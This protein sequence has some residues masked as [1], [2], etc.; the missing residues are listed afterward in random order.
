MTDNDKAQ[1]KRRVILEKMYVRVY[2]GIAN[3]IPPSVLIK[4]ID[5]IKSLEE[6]NP[7]GVIV[8]KAIYE[9]KIDLKELAKFAL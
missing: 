6:I 5:D 4:D 8:G 9:N 7:Y 1:D 3:N 2:L